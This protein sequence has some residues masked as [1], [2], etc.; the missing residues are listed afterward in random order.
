VDIPL[1]QFDFTMPENPA[2][3]RSPGV[4]PAMPWT[5]MN[6]LQ[7]A[8]AGLRVSG[9]GSVAHLFACAV[10]GQTLAVS[11]PKVILGGRL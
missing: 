11:V 4:S 9:E 8:L 10:G 2:I 5:S 1:F 6:H 3:A 7:Q